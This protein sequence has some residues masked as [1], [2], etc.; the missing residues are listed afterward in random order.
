MSH[1]NAAE[2]LK[3]IHNVFIFNNG[4]IIEAKDGSLLIYNQTYLEFQFIFYD[5]TIHITRSK[6]CHFY[7]S[8]QNTLS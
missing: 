2:L 7:D 4:L 1:L 5:I 3:V 8:R 6:K